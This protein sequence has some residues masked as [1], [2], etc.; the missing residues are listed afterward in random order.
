VRWQREPRER[1]D[2]ALGG[3]H[4]GAAEECMRRMHSWGVGRRPTDG[5]GLNWHSFWQRAPG[6]DLGSE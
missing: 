6:A 4:C 2:V 1:R 5:P 3:E